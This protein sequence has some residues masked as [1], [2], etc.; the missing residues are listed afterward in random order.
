M[1]NQNYLTNYKKIDFE[2]KKIFLDIFLKPKLYTKTQTIQTEIFF[3][4]DDGSDA[5][6]VM[7][8]INQ[9]IALIIDTFDMNIE[10]NYAWNDSNQNNNLKKFDTFYNNIFK[11]EEK[12]YKINYNITDSNIDINITSNTQNFNITQLLP[13]MMYASSFFIWRLFNNNNDA[14]ND[15]LQFIILSLH[16]LFRD[17]KFLESL[18]KNTYDEFIKKYT[19]YINDKKKIFNLLFNN[20]NLHIFLDHINTK[21]LLSNLNFLMIDIIDIINVIN[22]DDTD[23]KSRQSSENVDEKE[24]KSVYEQQNEDVKKFIENMNIEFYPDP[25]TGIHEIQYDLIDEYIYNDILNPYKKNIETNPL[26]VLK[27]K[28]IICKINDLFRNV[29]YTIQEKNTTG[30]KKQDKSKTKNIKQTKVA[31]EQVKAVK[32]SP[33]VVSEKV[34]PQNQSNTNVHKIYK[35]KASS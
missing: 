26:L 13:S 4:F 30:G 19:L 6:Q 10:Y 33:K 35:R 29:V 34:A 11:K 2:L 20:N 1:D 28:G 3:K 27:I 32:K 12:K 23:R 9:I 21:R 31:K 24:K 14:N 22:I 17:I 25:I 18:N 7:E 16:H 15:K 8:K 5:K